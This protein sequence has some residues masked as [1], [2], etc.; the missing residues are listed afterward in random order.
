M[1]AGRKPAP[2][3]K[4]PVRVRGRTDQ[5]RYHAGRGASIVAESD[6][7]ELFMKKEYSS[8]EFELVKFKFEDIILT[9]SLDDTPE[10]TKSDGD[11][12]G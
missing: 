12:W 9:G 1:G 11:D 8:P 2:A 3:A 10:A 5:L 4:V 6:R 7:K